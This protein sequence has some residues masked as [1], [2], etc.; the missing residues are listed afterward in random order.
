MKY[1]TWKLKWEVNP[2]TGSLEGTDPTSTVNNLNVRVEPA[3][4]TGD[5][6][7]PHT[8]IYAYLIKGSINP[9]NLTDWSVKETTVEAML[10]AA[11]ALNP[12]AVLENEVIKFPALDVTP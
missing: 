11:Q 12:D 3:F 8:L 2:V 9:A 5:L 4:A 1:Y 6:D 10:A 7:E